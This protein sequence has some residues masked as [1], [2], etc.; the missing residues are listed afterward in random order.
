MFQGDREGE[1][2]PQLI[3]EGVKRFSGFDDKVISLYARG[4][5]VSEIH[6]HLEEIYQTNISKDL[7]STV[8]DRSNRRSYYMAKQVPRRCISNIIFGL[9]TR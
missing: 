9:H 6:S 5:T 8:T 1:F 4:M 7:I 2:E 3:P